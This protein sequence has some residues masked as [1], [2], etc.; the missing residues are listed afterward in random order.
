MFWKGKKG[1]TVGMTVG[2][3]LGR[4]EEGQVM[5]IGREWHRKTEIEA[6]ILRG[7]IAREKGKEVWEKA[8][9]QYPDGNRVA[10][11]SLYCTPIEFS[12]L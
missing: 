1:M 7:G 9:P 3:S 8:G 10:I 11:G 12:L 4:G 5:R 6:R 2:M